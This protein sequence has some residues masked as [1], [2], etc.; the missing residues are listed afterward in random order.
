MVA[1]REEHGIELPELDL[2]G[3]LGIAYTAADDPAPVTAIARASRRSSPAS[4]RT[5]AWSRRASR[6]SRDARI[7]GPPGITL[8]ESAR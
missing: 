3:G 2:G 7:T 6:S 4:A 5:P 8:Y 1:I